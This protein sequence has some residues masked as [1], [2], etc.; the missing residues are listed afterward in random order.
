MHELTHLQRAPF[1]WAA[2]GIALGVL[3]GAWLASR[4]RARL[5]RAR[6]RE[7][8]VRAKRG[9]R[10]AERLLRAH[11]YSI[12]E[13]QLRASYTIL[14]DQVATPVELV[15][16]LVVERNGERRIAEVKTGAHA[17]RLSRAETRRQLLEY[18]L[19]T[20]TRGVLLVDPEAE[21]LTEI[22]F[23]ILQPQAAGA[24]A[25]VVALATSALL[26]AAWWW[27]RAA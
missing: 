25:W 13:R 26:I 1:L 18:Q 12:C 4:V 14:V 6:A 21:T 11:G 5:E 15:F 20:G 19:A 23:P 9:E 24:S 16:D 2:L 3:L 10:D 27:S 8:N 22:S 17:P 7:H